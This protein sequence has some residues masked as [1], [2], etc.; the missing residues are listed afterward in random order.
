MPGRHDLGRARLMFW[1]TPAIRHHP[2]VVRGEPS[3]GW[4][5]PEPLQVE[6]ASRLTTTVVT[7]ARSRKPKPME[8][9]EAN[10]A[11]A[12]D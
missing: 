4:T 10:I 9:F 5:K 8:T 3:R 7:M 6:R 11:E 1:A 2:T 12:E